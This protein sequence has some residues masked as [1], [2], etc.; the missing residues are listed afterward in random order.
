MKSAG[1]YNAYIFVYIFLV[2][3]LTSVCVNRLYVRG[4]RVVVSHNTTAHGHFDQRLHTLY[5][6]RWQ[7]LQDAN[8]L[9]TWRLASLSVSLAG[10]LAGWVCLDANEYHASGLCKLPVPRQPHSRFKANAPRTCVCVQSGYPWCMSLAGHVW[11]RGSGIQ[12]PEQSALTVA[13]RHRYAD[14]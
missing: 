12:Q 8:T 14:K 7:I 1:I 9:T 11:V 5:V 10:W 13:L 3:L 6:V 2:Q 4:V